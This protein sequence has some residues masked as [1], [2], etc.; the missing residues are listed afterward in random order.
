MVSMIGRKFNKL[1]VIEECKERT[2]NGTKIYKCLCDCGNYTNV[3][4]TQLRN[5]MTKSCGCLRVEISGQNNTAHRK[6]NTRLYNIYR[7][8][9]QRCYNKNNK[10]YKYYGQCGVSVYGDWRNDFMSFYNW[11]MNNGYKD[12][13]TIDRIDVNGNYEPNNCRWV[14][15]YEQQ[16]NRTNNLIVFYN[17]KKQTLTKWIKELNLKNSYS[18]IYKRL[19]NCGYDVYDAFYKQQYE[20]R[21]KEK[22]IENKLR[23]WLVSKGIYAF[24]VLK[25]NK[26]VPDIGYHHKVFN[27]GYMSTSGIP[28]L[29]ITI[30]GID[31][32]IEC[33][34]EKGLLSIQQKR[35]LEQIINSGGYGFILKPS[36][37]DDVV[38]FLQAVINYD[39]E[40]IDAMYQILLYQTY[41]L[42]NA[43]DRK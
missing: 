31:I 41:E 25:Q 33:K 19:V 17:N 32:R 24:G 27:G 5:G 39:Y 11:S 8:M 43:R 42:I 21:C 26:T 6:T 28:D 1:T 4:G 38:C 22:A 30:H 9:I 14:S 34:Q 16:N 10:D 12:N 3:I 13:L 29:S 18:T 23:K 40:S 15:Q 37:Y 7:G 36:N 20:Y 2:K 35:I